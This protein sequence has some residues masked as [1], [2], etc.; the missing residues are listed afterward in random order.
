MTLFIC[1]ALSLNML[2]DWRMTDAD[3]VSVLSVQPVADPVAWLAESE[4][5]HGPAV[6]AVGHADTARVFSSLLNREVPPNRANV[7]L[8]GDTEL[9][10]GQYVGPRLPEG[11]T[12]L[13]P[14]AVVR[15]VAVTVD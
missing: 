3:A 5:R 13:P 6:S 2:S 11:A 12:E 8:D 7:V 10:V 9:L 1:N 14:G 15:W 4:T